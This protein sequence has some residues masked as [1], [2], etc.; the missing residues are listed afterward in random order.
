MYNKIFSQLIIYLIHILY[1]SGVNK[2]E[3]KGAGLLNKIFKPLLGVATEGGTKIVSFRNSEI[4]LHSNKTAQ[5]VS[6]DSS[7]VKNQIFVIFKILLKFSQIFVKN[8]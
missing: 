8:F 3:A 6:L 2:K 1:F 7:T 4:N 5:A